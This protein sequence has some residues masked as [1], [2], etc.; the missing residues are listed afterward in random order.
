MTL[1]SFLNG[2]YLPTAHDNNMAPIYH[3]Q[4]NTLQNR[5]VTQQLYNYITAFK[6]KMNPY[7]GDTLLNKDP[8]R[9]DF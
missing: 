5:K 1:L 6:N 7:R 4:N 3:H 2:V 9:G 8:K